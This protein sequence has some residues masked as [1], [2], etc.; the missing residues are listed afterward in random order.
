M[1]STNREWTEEESLFLKNNYGKFGIKYCSDALNRTKT[2]IKNRASKL[3]IPRFKTP[4]DGFKFCGRCGLEKDESDFYTKTISY[5]KPCCSISRK[6]NG[7]YFRIW[8]YN[9]L[10]SH[11]KKGFT[12][13]ISTNEL[14]EVA[15]K[16]KN[17]P[18]CSKELAWTNRISMPNS[19]TLD[20]INNENDIS[21]DNYL[22]IC[23]ECNTSKSNRSIQEFLDYIKNVKSKLEKIIETKKLRN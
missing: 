17:C 15:K 12:V 4:K 1:K 10:K 22:I 9:S 19:P 5:C 2:S 6:E 3:E 11:I 7:N 20:R 14:K 13:N 21:N 18:Y 8:A 23:R 16:S